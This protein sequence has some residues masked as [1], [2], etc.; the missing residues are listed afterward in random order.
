ML[1]LLRNA[2]ITSSATSLYCLLCVALKFP[3]CCKSER[4]GFPRE[5]CAK[6]HINAEISKTFMVK[7]SVVT[8]FP[9]REYLSPTKRKITN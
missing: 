4:E 3:Q 9:K 8:N 1:I 6:I 5:V 7:Q 2:D